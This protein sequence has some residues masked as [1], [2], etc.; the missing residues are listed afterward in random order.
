MCAHAQARAHTHT[1]TLARM[2]DRRSPSLP[3]PQTLFVLLPDWK[4]GHRGECAA[5]ARDGAGTRTAAKPTAD[6]MRVWQILAQLDG[7]AD[8]RGVAAH[9]ERA[10]RAVVAAV[11]TSKQGCV[12]D[13][14]PFIVLTETKFR[15]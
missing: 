6:Q 13:D 1:Q 14:T 5:A 2:P 10:A 9:Q 15:V 4:A 7:A 8:W 3:N 12:D 11:R